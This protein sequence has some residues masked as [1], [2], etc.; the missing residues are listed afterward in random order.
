MMTSQEIT[1]KSENIG[2]LLDE[3]ETINE[4]LFEYLAEAIGRSEIT[5]KSQR[6]ITTAGRLIEEAKSDAEELTRQAIHENNEE[7]GNNE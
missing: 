4:M 5:E 1:N 7:E 6:L 2:N 3:V